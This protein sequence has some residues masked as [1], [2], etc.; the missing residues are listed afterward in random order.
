MK[1]GALYIPFQVFFYTYKVS[2]SIPPPSHNPPSTKNP[3]PPSHTPKKFEPEKIL[4]IRQSNH[5]IRSQ[6]NLE[7]DIKKIQIVINS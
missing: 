1:K 6:Y 2:N 7:N 4:N 5:Q 3:P